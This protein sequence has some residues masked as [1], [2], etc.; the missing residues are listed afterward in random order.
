MKTPTTPYEAMLLDS[1]I[2]IL[3]SD[4]RKDELV[5]NTRSRV[6]DSTKSSWFN[7]GSQVVN[8]VDTTTTQKEKIMAKAP[9]KREPKVE[10]ATPVS[11]ASPTQA[12]KEAEVKA[13]IEAK[14]AK[15][16]ATAEAKAAKE[17]AAV[18][19]AQER[20]A[21]RLEREA[22]KAE[23]AAELQA[24]G[25]KYIGSMLALAER[26]KEGVYVKSATGQL[27]SNDEL[28]QAFDGV[29]PINVVNTAMTLLGL[30]VNPYSALNIGQQS[31]NMR[32]RLRGA[33][34]KGVVTIDA[35]R[36]H[37]VENDYDD[38]AYIETKRAE[39][40]AKAAAAKAER[41]AKSV[42]AKK[43]PETATA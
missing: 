38:T 27:R 41:E 32:N 42:K 6:L 25:K 29:G 2:R 19:K 23:K 13:K 36:A 3:K 5:L 16:A 34:R 43:E 33:V 20:E 15:L 28:A 22:A 12:E 39:R 21:K 30:E 4:P 14:A 35:I 17:S 10:K 26:V 40:E 37:I 1:A 31:M 11:A 18:R 8:S 24:S 7:Q 9:S